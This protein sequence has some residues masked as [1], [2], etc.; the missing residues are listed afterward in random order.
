MWDLG[1]QNA[2]S[3][4]RGTVVVVDEASM[5]GTRDLARLVTHVRD[6][7]RPLEVAPHLRFLCLTGRRITAKPSSS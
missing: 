1:D 3:M 5:L 2:P 4:A 6:V 7:S